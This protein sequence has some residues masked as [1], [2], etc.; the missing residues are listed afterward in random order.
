MPYNPD[1]PF[2]KALREHPEGLAAF[3]A[4]KFNDDAVGDKG[5]VRETT[6]QGGAVVRHADPYISGIEAAADKAY[7][8]TE[9]IAAYSW[10]EIVDPRAPDNFNIVFLDNE[11]LW[12]NR[13]RE[14]PSG[15]R[16]ALWWAVRVD[17][18]TANPRWVG[19]EPRYEGIVLEPGQTMG[20]G[21]VIIT[22]AFC[23]G[24]FSQIQ[25]SA[26]E[27]VTDENQREHD[28]TDNAKELINS[29]NNIPWG[30]R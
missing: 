8:V 14:Q 19:P 10:P 2:T 20:E 18:D 4:F 7:A 17:R 29:I 22:Q 15:A 9:T 28:E 24:I 3:F 21:G 11:N 13:F 27:E 5:I 26:P 16:V 12:W 25:T 23:G 6:W 30:L 1:D